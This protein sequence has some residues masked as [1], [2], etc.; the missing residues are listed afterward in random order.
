M[1]VLL[2]VVATLLLAWSNGANDNFKGVATLHGSGVLSYRAALLWAALATLAGGLVSVLLAD[3]LVKTF[4]GD[5]ILHGGALDPS[6]LAAMMAAAGATVLLASVVGMPTST[7]HALMGAL[8]GVVLAVDPGRIR[9]DRVGVLF[10][11]PMLLSPIIAIVAA[12][13]LFLGVRFVGRRLSKGSAPCLCVGAAEVQTEC[14]ADGT[15]ALSAMQTG[16]LLS[17]RVGSASEC[18]VHREQSL[19]RVDGR[20][21]ANLAHGLSGGAVC[22]ARALNDTPKIAAVLLTTG[23]VAGLGHAGTLTVVALIVVAGGLLQGRRVARTMSSRITPLGSESGL[24]AN[25]VTAGLVLWASRL[26]LPVSTTHVSCSSIFGIGAATRQANRS[27]I[28]RILMTWI[29]TLPFAAVLGAVV[30][31]LLSWLISG[32]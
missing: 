8:L 20:S 6:M 14:A 11:G 27:T 16:P 1:T 22:F 32:A 12:A 21:L 28:S 3:H 23:V 10:L 17:W 15:V 31:S 18:A 24:S 13:L 9:L 4:S 19:V 26:G 7:T 30:Y 2:L 5:A 25:L 29:T